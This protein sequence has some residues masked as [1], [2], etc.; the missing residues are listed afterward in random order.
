[1]ANRKKAA[2]LVLSLCMLWGCTASPKQEQPTEPPRETRPVAQEFAPRDQSF[3]LCY[4]ADAGFNPYTCTRLANRPVLSL[5]Y[6]GLFF[7]S[8]EYR[9]EPV[10]C[11]TYSC[12]DDLKTYVFTLEDATFSDGS[13]LGVQDVIASLQAAMG[14]PVY[15]N[16]LRHVKELSATAEGALKITL[17]TAYENLPL[18]LDIPVVRAQDV[19]SD[20]P[21]G[22]GPYTL[23]GAGTLHLALR[24]NRW[25]EYPPAVEYA[26]IELSATRTPADI[27]DEF[28]FGQTDLVCADPGAVS[29]VEYRC[30]YELWDCATGIMLYLGVNAQDGCALNSGTVRA[31][32]TRALDRSALTAVYQGFAEETCLPVSPSSDFYDSTL[33]ARYGYDPQVFTAALTEAGMRGTQVTLLVNGDNPTRVEVAN[34]LAS[35][36]NACGLTVTVDAPQGDSYKKALRSGAFDLYLGEVRL[37]PNFDLSVFYRENGALNYGGIA[38]A[39]INDLCALALENSGNYY[40]LFEAVLADGQLCP[41]LFRTYAVYASRGTATGL[42]PGLDNVFHTSNARQLSD[43]RTEWVE[44]N[45]PDPT[46][47]TQAP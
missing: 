20:R 18:L 29:Y 16:R 8:S 9:A 42:L 6:Q 22:T 36:L 13:P 5:L 1:M 11:K 12:S 41:L 30:D 34:I 21:L 27:R 24:G 3:G 31:A 43:A 10:L 26:S 32:L 2:A 39:T 46:D 33:A 4:Q 25:S 40:D 15:G 19:E 14:S 45:I 7:V 35:Q 28:E 17:D 38:D 47:A 37:S 44:P 23:E